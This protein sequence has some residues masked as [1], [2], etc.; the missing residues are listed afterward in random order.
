MAGQGSRPTENEENAGSH[1]TMRS[2][3][4]SIL[5]LQR[6]TT[7]RFSSNQLKIEP[8]DFVRNFIPGVLR[9][10]FGVA[11]SA[12]SLPHLPI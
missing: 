8:F 12:H 1:I 2:Q 3:R 4:T 5:G 9:N 6:A 10:G 7:Y 11:A